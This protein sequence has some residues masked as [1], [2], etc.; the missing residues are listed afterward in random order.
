MKSVES[1]VREVARLGNVNKNAV[2]TRTEV[3]IR[4]AVD[5]LN[6]VLERETASPFEALDLEEGLQS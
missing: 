5:A 1:I 4:Q 2:D 3:A 6:W